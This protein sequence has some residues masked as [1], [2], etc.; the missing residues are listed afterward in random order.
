MT[1]PNA[2]PLPPLQLQSDELI[3]LLLYLN[4]WMCTNCGYGELLYV[5]TEAYETKDQKEKLVL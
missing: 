4:S 1:K 2:D 3:T 5:Y